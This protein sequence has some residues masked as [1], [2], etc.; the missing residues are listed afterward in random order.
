[1]HGLI[2]SLITNT[3][4]IVISA[5]NHKLK[6]FTEMLKDNKSI[7]FIDKNIDKL[8]ESIDKFLNKKNIVKNEFSKN[9]L[10]TA[11]IILEDNNK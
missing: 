9:L 8:P 3:P 2:F 10:I 1:M 11:K 6:E 7:I 4:C 5:F